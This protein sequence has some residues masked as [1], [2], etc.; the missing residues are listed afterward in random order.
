MKTLLKTI[1]IG[2]VSILALA[3][4]YIFLVSEDQTIEIPVKAQT[5]SKPTTHKTET[6]LTTPQENHIESDTVETAKP[7]PKQTESN[8]L[9]ELLIAFDKQLIDE[10]AQ[11]E[12]WEMVRSSKAFKD[13]IK[14]LEQS[15]SQNTMDTQTRKDLAQ[16]YVVKLLTM[17]D[18]PEKAIWANKAEKQWNAVLQIDP[19]DWEARKSTAF[20]LSQYPDFLNRQGDSI[21]H[22]EKLVELQSTLQPEPKFENTYLELS[23][24]YLKKGDRLSAQETAVEG[25]AL[26]PGNQQLRERSKILSN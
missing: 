26:F 6:I 12:F 19:D 1:A 13:K 4:C 17:P 16:L 23:R 20:S 22:Y 5:P 2:T 21:D 3:V 24:L 10:D 9:D 14:A 11:L 8:R 18:S 15:V 7:A 25:L